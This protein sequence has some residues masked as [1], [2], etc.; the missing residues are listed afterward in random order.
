VN[1]ANISYTRN[2]LSEL[3]SR[4]REGETIVITDRQQPV[5]RLEPVAG[6][7]A[8]GSPW[9]ADLARRGLVR[10]ARTHLDAKALGALPLPTP[11]GG[12][13]ILATLAAEREEGR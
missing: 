6:A 9:Q 2:H 1:R 7:A 10:P 12:G 11:Q 4:V 13:D 8:R 3:I 5:A